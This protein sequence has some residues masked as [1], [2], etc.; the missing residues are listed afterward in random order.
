MKRHSKIET[1]ATI[2]SRFGTYQYY[3]FLPFTL[4]HPNRTPQ[5]VS[6]VIQSYNSDSRKILFDPVFRPAIRYVFHAFILILHFVDPFFSCFY[7][8]EI[9]GSLSAFFRSGV[10]NTQDGACQRLLF[11]RH[12]HLA[13][14]R[15]RGQLVLELVVVVT[16]LS[17]RPSP[18]QA[19]M[20]AVNKYD[21]CIDVT[22]KKTI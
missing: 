21:V 12:E 5:H 7:V 6:I 8:F 11:R 18:S 1:M 19:S 22:L 2:L 10:V 13:S 15:S 20:K 17:L 3:N 16:P 9:S 14:G 4:L